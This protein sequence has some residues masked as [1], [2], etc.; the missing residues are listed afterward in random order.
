MIPDTSI[1]GDPDVLPALCFDTLERHTGRVIVT[2]AWTTVEQE[3]VTAF[4]ETTRDPDPMHIDPEWA[5]SSGPYG[6]TVLAGMHMLALLPHMTRGAGL[7]IQGVKLAMNYGFNRVRFTGELPVDAPFRNRVELMSVA[8]RTDGKAT[9]V[10]LNT[11]EVRDRK[12]PALVAE[13]VNLLW[14][15]QQA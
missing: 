4:A 12:R 10:T 1:P 15:D 13:W 6:R 14:P 2:S 8:R 3:A 5:S 7:S 11:F 9:I